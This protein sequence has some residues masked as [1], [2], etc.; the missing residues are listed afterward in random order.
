MR[1]IFL[2]MNVSLDGYFE[3]PDHDISWTKSDF[4]AFSAEESRAVDT[5]LLGHRT[6]DL[7]KRF[8]P[9]PQAAESA[10]EIASFMNDRRKLVA[11]HAPFEPGWN[12]VTVLS[13]A[14][15]PAQVRQLKQQPGGN[16]IMMGSNELCVSLMREGLVDE[17]Q[18]L[19][20]PVVLGDGTSLFA[21]LP[22]R[23]GLRLAETRQFKGGTVL[24]RYE[25]A[26]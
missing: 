4:D 6:Y 20:N 25:P 7:M 2:F 21:G 13:G 14:D 17:F 9:T 16:I 3:G 18:L 1:R 8:W 5:I 26:G 10:P 15:V 22:D 19:V 24:L 23:A 12:H 11:S